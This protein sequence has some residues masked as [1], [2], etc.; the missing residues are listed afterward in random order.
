MGN[1]NIHYLAEAALVDARNKEILIVISS[2][3]GSGI[4]SED[5]EKWQAHQFIYSDNLTAPKARVLLAL[6]LT[7]TKDPTEI[8]RIFAEY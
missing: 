5:K 4:V 1:G 8:R 7:K 6:A 3:T 2:R